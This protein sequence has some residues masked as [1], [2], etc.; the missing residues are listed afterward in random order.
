MHGLRMLAAA[1][2]RTQIKMCDLHAIQP[3]SRRNPTAA[4]VM[5][6]ITAQPLVYIAGCH[7][8]TLQVI[9]YGLNGILLSFQASLVE[10]LL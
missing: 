7:A 8:G 10:T 9:Y 4:L 5:S 1:H 3:S 2:K 6:K